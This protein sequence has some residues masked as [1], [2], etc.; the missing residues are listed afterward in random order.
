MK[1]QAVITPE[2]YHKIE[3]YKYYSSYYLYCTVI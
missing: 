1:L 2:K 3:K